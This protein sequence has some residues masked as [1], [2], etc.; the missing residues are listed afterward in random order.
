ML[1]VAS[2]QAGKTRLAAA[3]GLN[4]ALLKPNSLIVI[5]SPSSRQSSELALVVFN[6]YD[7]LGCPIRARKRTELQLCLENGSRIIAL[8]ESERTT[9][10]LSSCSLLIIDEAA[11]VSDDLYM[12]VRPMLA[13][14]RGRLLCLSTPYGRRGWFWSAWSSEERWRRVNVTADQISRITP[15]FLAEERVSLGERFYQQEYFGAWNDMVNAAFSHED[16]MAAFDCNLQ[17]LILGGQ[18]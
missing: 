14:S 18:R 2:R 13:V 8:P 4:T 17:P 11:R 1:L 5:L 15:E 3:I 6:Y 7:T 12:A 10:G 16:I 9:R